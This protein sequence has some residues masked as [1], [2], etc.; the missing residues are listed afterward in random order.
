MNSVCVCAFACRT[1]SWRKERSSDRA[2]EWSDD[3]HFRAPARDRQSGL[4]AEA[5]RRAFAEC[6]SPTKE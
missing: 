5:C 6:P 3:F 1:L 4:V 2:K